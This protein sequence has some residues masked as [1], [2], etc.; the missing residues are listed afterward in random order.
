MM[1]DYVKLFAVL[2]G[3]KISYIWNGRYKVMA[4]IK[5]MYSIL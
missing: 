2:C 3:I 1:Y 4:M 5:Y